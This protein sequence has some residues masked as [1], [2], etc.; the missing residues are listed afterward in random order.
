M[1]CYNSK[2]TWQRK[3]RGLHEN[4]T[5]SISRITKLERSVHKLELCSRKECVEIAGTPRDTF[6]VVLE[7]IIKLL[8]NTGVNLTKKDLVT[9]LQ[10]RQYFHKSFKL[11]TCWANHDYRLKGMR[12]LD[13][14]NIVEVSNTGN[15]TGGNVIEFP[16]KRPQMEPL[17][18]YK[19]QLIHKPYRFHI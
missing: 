4:L 11:K 7:D 15:N 19:L 14:L 8:S 12:F 10:F 9:D 6:H 2:L 18:L 3:R 17:N 16:L 13:V 1:K 5:S